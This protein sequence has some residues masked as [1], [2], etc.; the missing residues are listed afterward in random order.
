MAAEFKHKLMP[1]LAARCLR[2]CVI[3]LI[4]S[5]FR[6]RELGMGN[7]RADLTTHRNGLATIPNS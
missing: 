5:P 2:Q 4:A 7:A 1:S 3:S 6:P